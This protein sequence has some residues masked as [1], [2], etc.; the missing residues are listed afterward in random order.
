MIT[1][2][3]LSTIVHINET[4]EN[5]RNILSRTKSDFFLYYF[6]DSHMGCFKLKNNLNCQDIIEK[7][8]PDYTKTGQK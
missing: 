1:K 3:Q 6:I 8:D 5:K 4:E 2:Y 7:V